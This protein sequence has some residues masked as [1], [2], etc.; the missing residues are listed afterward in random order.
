MRLIKLISIEKHAKPDR[1][2][3]I[4]KWVSNEEKNME[5]K[6]KNY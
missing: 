6:K 4:L 2:K 3:L 1:I 5:I